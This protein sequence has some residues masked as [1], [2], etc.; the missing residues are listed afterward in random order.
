[1]LIEGRGATFVANNREDSFIVSQML[2]ERCVNLLDIRIA[3]I[4][5][6]NHALVYVLYRNSRKLIVE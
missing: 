4:F 2:F 1:M 5:D 6:A 3:L